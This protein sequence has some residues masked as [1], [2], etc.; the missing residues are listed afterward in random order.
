MLSNVDQID[1]ISNKTGSKRAIQANQSFSNF[2]KQLLTQKKIP[3]EPLSMTHI[4]LIL[5]ELASL[6]SNNFLNSHQ[7][8]EREGRLYSSLIENRAFGF[9]HG[10]GRSG[11]IIAAQPKAVGST[12]LYR[13][14]NTFLLKLA[15]QLGFKSAKSSI[16][17]PVATGMGLFFSMSALK[18]ISP[19]KNLVI[20]SRVDHKSPLKAIAL[21]N[22][23][24]IVIDQVTID[25]R[26]Q[27]NLLAIEDFCGRNK[28]KIL[29]V[30]ST[31]GCFAPREP[32]NVV[33]ISKICKKFQLSHVVN[34][35]FGF[36]VPFVM[37][38]LD[39]AYKLHPLNYVV[40]ST[41]KNLMVPVG[42]SVVFSDKKGIQN[43]SKCYPG[44][45]SSYPI[46]DVFVTLLSMGLNKYFELL[47]EREQNY[48]YLKERMSIL[49]SKY[50]ERI[51]GGSN[52]LSIGLTLQNVGNPTE[53]GS[54]LFFRGVTGC[55][56]VDGTK[57]V[58]LDQFNGDGIIEN[59]ESHSSNLFPYLTAAASIGIQKQQIDS[60]IQILEE[61]LDEL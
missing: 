24:P 21:A 28:E 56:V 59:W 52:P 61:I 23:I 49:A 20:L 34:N 55:R 26:I 14:T 46:V 12:T 11:D 31:T 47:K 54:Q 1:L 2:T 27:T 58:D 13:L 9:A 44:R 32:D 41:D 4:Q 10:I 57:N 22:C 36:Q 60:F 50:S 42:G 51:I 19:E 3:D 40:Q 5:S 17:L 43:L 45:A 38:Q 6:D 8:G 37:N 15:K 7:I 18:T 35:S 25:D 16:V 53:I 29:C 30:L 33:E 39:I 48:E